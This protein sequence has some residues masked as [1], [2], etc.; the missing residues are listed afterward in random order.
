MSPFFVTNFSLNIAM[1]L[2]YDFIDDNG[3]YDML[4]PHIKHK[5]LRTA[6]DI[7][8]WWGPWS[9]WWHDKVEHIEIFEPN[10]DILP[11]LKNNISNLQNCT[12][13]EVA[14]GDKNGH[15][16]MDYVDHS[17]TYHINGTKGTIQIKKLDAFNFDNVD[18]IKIDAEGYELPVLE[19]AKETILHNKPWIQIEAN[20]SGARYGRTKV[21]IANFLDSLGMKRKAKKW[22][23]QVWYFK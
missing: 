9:L 19:G 7:G 15:V 20:K 1:P 21:D 22:P 14:L 17:G 13:H 12:L 3:N 6:I 10:E 16:S 2:Q 23:D 11:K 5:H 8:A 4:H 18:L